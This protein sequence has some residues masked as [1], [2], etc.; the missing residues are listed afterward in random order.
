MLVRALI[1]GL[2]VAAAAAIAALL[3]GDF[4]DTHWRIVGTSLGF[5]VFTALATVGDVLRRGTRD[6]R[7]AVG[8][9]T[10]GCSAAAFALLLAACWIDSDAEALWRAWGSAAVLALCGSL[11]SLVLRRRRHSDTSAL[12]TLVVVSLATS[13]LVTLVAVLAITGAVQDDEDDLARGAAILLVVML[14]TTVLPPI[15][16]RLRGSEAALSRNA[17]A[18]E[19]TAVATRLERS[20]DAEREA[21]TLRD[22]AARARG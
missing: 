6:W 16:R 12:T 10:A 9:A 4:S 11:W 20:G 17:L 21:A 5:S 1:A 3:T 2:C 7:A 8:G 14:L 22:L 13:A 18:D 19:I 15:L